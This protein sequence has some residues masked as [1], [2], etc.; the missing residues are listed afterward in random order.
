VAAIGAG[1][2]SFVG[3]VFGHYRILAKYLDG[4]T[5]PHLLLGRP[6]DLE[7]LID[8]S[9]DFA[10]G[11]ESAARGSKSVQLGLENTANEGAKGRPGIFYWSDG[12]EARK[13]Y[14][15]RRSE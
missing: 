13:A 9:I 6:V 5:L 10:T 8:V 11:L 3:K 1:R 7:R 4:T 12:E 15:L 14:D 2:D